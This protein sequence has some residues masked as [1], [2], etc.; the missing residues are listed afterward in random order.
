MLP[1]Y[2]YV[3]LLLLLLLHHSSYTYCGIQSAIRGCRSVGG[4]VVRPTSASSGG[5]ASF[6]TRNRVSPKK[7]HAAL[8]LNTSSSWDG[9]ARRRTT[10]S[11]MVVD[12][13]C[14]CCFSTT[15]PN[16]TQPGATIWI[17][18]KTLLIK[19]PIRSHPSGL[20]LI[21]TKQNQCHCYTRH[22]VHDDEGS[23]GSLNHLHCDD[24]SIFLSTPKSASQP[25]ILKANSHVGN[26]FR[27][28]SIEIRKVSSNQPTS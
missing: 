22:R 14:C 25:I 24:V 1:L 18:A 5:G 2:T 4:S 17:N 8:H 19:L 28:S 21:I 9:G 16:V 23:T 10:M 12:G 15:I 6:E 26:P 20:S 7:L 3:L 27:S 13:D 11:L